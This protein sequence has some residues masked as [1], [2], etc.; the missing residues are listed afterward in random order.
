MRL[1]SKSYSSRFKHAQGAGPGDC[2]K[3]RG[4][5]QSQ[6][7]P[8]PNAGNT[9]AQLPANASATP[10][11]PRRAVSVAN[12]P[13]VPAERQW[14]CGTDLMR[15][16]VS[17]LVAPGARAKTTWLLTCALSCASG[18]DL[19]DAY[20]YGGPHRVLYLSAEDRRMRLRFGY[21]QPCNTTA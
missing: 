19:L 7:Q 9:A 4:N 15:G 11:I 12:L 8:G 17:M 1:A 6:Q 5:Q 18:R 2:A 16:A 20:V 21:E 10:V 13:A 14:L 3:C